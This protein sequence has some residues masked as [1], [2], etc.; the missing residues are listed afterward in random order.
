[1]G[2]ETLARAVLAS[3]IL[4]C[5]TPSDASPI[6]SSPPA[7]VVSDP[8]SSL[9]MPDGSVATV[10]SS[11]TRPP[12]S[13]RVRPAAEHLF[14]KARLLINPGPGPGPGTTIEHA[15]IETSGG[16]ILSVGK[17]ETLP[18]PAGAKVMDFSDKVIIPGLVDTHGHLYTRLSGGWLPTD[19]RLPT[20]Y[21]AA[22]VTSVG[23]PGSMDPDAD[24]ALRQQIDSGDAP[25]PR[26]FLAGEYI[27]MAPTRIPWMHAV[28]TP[29][30]ARLKVDLLAAQGAAA[31]KIYDQTAG[32]V[33]LAAVDE[34]HEH[35]MRVWAHVGAVTWRQAMDMGVD[36]LFHGVT[37][38]PDGRAPGST[39]ADYATWAKETASLDLSRPEYQQ[40]FRMAAARKVVLTPTIVV[41]ET[42]GPGYDKLHHLEEQQKYYSSAGW[43]VVQDIEQGRSDAF[44]KFPVEAVR[45]E[46]PKNKEFVRAARDAGCILATG[47]DVVVLTM[48]PGWSLWRE[49]DLFAEAG[50]SPMDVL[51]A[52]TWNGIYAIGKTDQLGSV[53]AGKLADFVVLDANPLDAIANVRKVH[54]VVK[55]GVIYDPQQL[56]KPM[57]GTVE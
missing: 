29:E 44:A 57:E 46:I 19:H 35:G 3:C 15:I 14:F 20:F 52:A 18:I 28:A 31:V 37:A 45:M 5:G 9:P 26:Y 8:S 55:A 34:A 16:K 4:A 40:M 54:R 50:L 21:I 1:M 36:Q 11:S 23:D 13:A 27:Q 12:S 48:L 33:M 7:A 53:E 49:M 6:P 30:E 38:M 42:I 32:D 56:L 17:A 25:G 2:V 41:S 39:P 47:T 22:G 10:A 43:R 24:L 51:R